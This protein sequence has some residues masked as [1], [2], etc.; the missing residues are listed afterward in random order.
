[1]IDV[2]MA[3]TWRPSELIQGYRATIKNT[4]E[5]TIPKDFSEDLAVEI[6][7]AIFDIDF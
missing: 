2:T 4:I 1:M 7:L 3:Q 5:K 6:W